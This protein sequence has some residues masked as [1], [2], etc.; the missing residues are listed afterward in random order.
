MGEFKYNKEYVLDGSPL[1]Y[2]DMDIIWT[3][4]H[5][6]PGVASSTLPFIYLI[7][8]EQN[9]NQTVN[10]IKEVFSRI[11]G[12]DDILDPYNGLY[13]GMPTGNQYVLPYFSEDHHSISQTWGDA[14]GLL[15]LFKDAVAAAKA[16]GKLFSPNTTITMPKSWTGKG[17]GSVTTQFTLFNTCHLDLDPIKRNKRFIDVLIYRNLHA[18]STALTS[19]PPS[20]YEVFIPGVKYIPVG[21]ITA[22]EVKNLG[23]LT[24]YDK[25]GIIPDAWSVSITISELIP[26][27]RNLYHEVVKSGGASTIGGSRVITSSINA[28]TQ[29]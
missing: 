11:A 5:Y 6:T 12:G 8:Y 15:N 20:L 14:D 24:K 28:I 4:A 16:L 27:S 29:G 25:Y 21:V 18:Q 17:D 26:E 23:T 22:L 19:Y 1:D 13:S 2:R 9:R 7:E 10:Q 3:P